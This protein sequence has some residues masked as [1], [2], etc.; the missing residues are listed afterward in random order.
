VP[1]AFCGLYGLRISN[2][3]PWSKDVFPLAPSF[4][5]AGWFAGN[6]PDMQTLHRF[7]LGATKPDRELRGCFLDFEALGQ[8]ADDDVAAAVR[9]AAEHYAPPADPA[10][11]QQLR[12]SFSRARATYTVLQSAE[13]Y[14]VHAEWLDK[15]R[16]LYS[17]PVWERLDRGRN[18]T[19]AELDT[20][21]VD[22]A[23]IKLAWTN[24]FL[25]YDYLVLPA[26]PFPA[27]KK[28]DCTQE[29]RNRLLDLNTP[30]SLGGLPVL[31]IPVELPSGLTTGL[32]IVVTSNQS[33]VIPWALSQVTT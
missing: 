5:T 17:A 23:A 20:A 8:I 10:T 12:E 22:H 24:Y 19:T 16:E 32:Q 26:T 3:H 33:P 31:S 6:A 4:D 21:H 11:S 9:K 14:H 7:L 18:W 30:A 25:A 28:S 2:D 1:A 27:L 29:N 13:A 15:H